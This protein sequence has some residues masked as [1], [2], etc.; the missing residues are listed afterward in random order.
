MQM[1]NMAHPYLL[2]ANHVHFVGICG[3]IGTCI[4][5]KRALV[6]LGGA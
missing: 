5:L 2:E 4:E 6:S 1:H 3:R